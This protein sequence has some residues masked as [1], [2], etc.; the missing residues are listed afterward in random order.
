VKRIAAMT[1]GLLAAAT[2]GHCVAAR[3]AVVEE[4]ASWRAA[5][6]RAL[7]PAL[8]AAYPDVSDWTVTPLLGRGQDERLQRQLPGTVN[9]VHLGSRSAVRLSWTQ[10]KRQAHST[11]WFAVEGM[12][13][14]LTATATIHSG[15]ALT[16]ELVEQGVRNTLAVG[17]T[18]VVSKQALVGMRARVTMQAGQVICA[19]SVEPRP[20]VARGENVVVRSV[21]GAVTVMARGVAQQDGALGQVL[22]I[23]N[24]ANGDT[25]LAAVSAAGEVAVHE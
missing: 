17:C 13:D 20:P 3:A 15:S 18:P 5:A 10:G 7:L 25:Y 4:P 1:C 14:L 24:P 22:R 12:Q 19:Q 21:A 9:I 11:I 16:P 23:K 6:D 2:A 8:H